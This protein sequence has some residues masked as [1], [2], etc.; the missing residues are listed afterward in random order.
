[1]F[2]PAAIRSVLALAALAAIGIPTFLPALH[3]LPGMSHGDCGCGGHLTVGDPV[4]DR[5]SSIASQSDTCGGCEHGTCVTTVDECVAG[6]VAREG[7]GE[8]RT[9]AD[10]DCLLCALFASFVLS[11]PEQG[12][13]LPTIDVVAVQELPASA[14]VE[15]DLR[16]AACRGPPAVV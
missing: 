15:F 4:Y 14:P 1:M 12:Y 6:P 11:Q 9:A 5:A 3:L 13:V 10:S 2:F 8:L 16:S 7:R